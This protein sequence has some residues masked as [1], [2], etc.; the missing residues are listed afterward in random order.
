[1]DTGV[2]T[3]SRG[4]RPSE[5]SDVGSAIHRILVASM[6]TLAVGVFAGALLLALNSED[7]DAFD[8][9]YPVLGVS[10]CLTGGLIAWKRPRNS[11]GWVMLA[12]GLVLLVQA[13]ALF[14]TP[15]ARNSSVPLRSLADEAAW[16][17]LW[18]WVPGFYLI[19][20]VLFLFPDGRPPTPR[21]NWVL[22]LA[23]AFLV[24]LLVAVVDVWP[25]RSVEF[26]DK[27]GLIGEISGSSLLDMVANSGLGLVLLLGFVALVS[28]FFRSDRTVKQQ[29]KWLVWGAGTTWLATLLIA[30]T[31]PIEPMENST[32]VIFLFVA[33]IS[34]PISTAIAV[35]RYRLYDIDR[36]ISRTVTYTLVVGLLAA[37]FFGL[38]TALAWLLSPDQPLVVAAST[39]AVF[40][41]FNPLRRRT[42][43]AVDRRFNRSRYDAERVIETFTGTLR[44]RV[45]PDGVVDGWVGVVS[46]T[47][48]PTR[49]GAWVRK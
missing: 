49:M 15:V 6:V 33:M 31:S 18:L 48:Q 11:I 28:R 9:L 38:V 41:L 39:L 2:T 23:G 45:D 20:L 26:L 14:F 37:V 42:Q 44:D 17:Q 47:M 22:W 27:E 40:A 34:I 29:L 5:T 24:A 16:L 30:F 25:R 21:W 1:M 32:Y 10:Y 36:I 12:A 19:G 35:T 7:S 43:T 3:P 4:R 8:L 13:L 46:E